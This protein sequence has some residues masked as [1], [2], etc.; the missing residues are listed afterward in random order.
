M[1]KQPELNMECSYGVGSDRYPCTI[2]TMNK[3]RKTVTTRDA[4]YK[5]TDSNGQSESQ[6]YT[7]EANPNG[8]LQDWTLRKNGR[9]VRRGEPLYAQALSLEGYR[10]YQDPC[11]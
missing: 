10:A 11:F 8:R 1:N 4:S 6:S 9:Y 7:Y 3:T 2:V 5:R